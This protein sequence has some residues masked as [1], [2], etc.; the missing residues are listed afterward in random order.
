MRTIVE[1]ML[2]QQFLLDLGTYMQTAAHIELAVWQTTM[3]AEGIDPH[4]VEEY[5]SYVSLK[6]KTQG[7]CPV[8]WCSWR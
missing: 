7:C 4:S 2:P 3:H 8:E 1:R 6:L 5:R